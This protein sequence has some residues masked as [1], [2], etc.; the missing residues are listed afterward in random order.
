MDFASGN[1]Q[2]SPMP[3]SDDRYRHTK[4]IG[5]H[6]WR[7]QATYVLLGLGNS[8]PLP[9]LRL[10]NDL[11]SSVARGITN[12]GIKQLAIFSQRQLVGTDDDQV[13]IGRALGDGYTALIAHKLLS[14]AARDAT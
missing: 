2:A 11:Q 6:G 12:I 9:E 5:E 10:G 7:V 3:A 13:D 14:F 8:E 1:N 4:Q